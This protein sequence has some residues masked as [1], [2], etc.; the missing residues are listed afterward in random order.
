MNN[1]ILGLRP[2]SEVEWQGFVQ[3]ELNR[4]YPVE[5]RV[6]VLALFLLEC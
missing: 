4:F 1:L 3:L 6:Y 5:E 2:H